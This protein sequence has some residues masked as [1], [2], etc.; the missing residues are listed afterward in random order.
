M[1]D[2]LRNRKH[3]PALQRAVFALCRVVDVL[4]LWQERHRERRNLAMLSDHMLK[5][6]GVSRADID[7]EMRKRFWRR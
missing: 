5:D 6:L 7:V 4:L 3:L 1:S 2:V